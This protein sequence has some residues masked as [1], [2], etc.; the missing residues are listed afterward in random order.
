M[1]KTIVRRW[2]RSTLRTKALS[3]LKTIEQAFSRK[4]SLELILLSCKTKEK[5][6][7]VITSK[8][9]SHNNETDLRNR[10]E[11]IWE[12]AKREI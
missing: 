3:T 8:D 7:T 5:V 9:V 2:S 10:K 11:T 12:E 4:V 1:K 6:I